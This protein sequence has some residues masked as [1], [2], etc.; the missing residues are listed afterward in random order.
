M[1][2]GNESPGNESPGKWISILYRGGE[3]YIA[4]QLE[5]LQIKRGQHRFLIELF[6]KDGVCQGDLV[7]A[8]SIDKSTAAHALAKLEKNGY[9]KRKKDNDDKR[10]VRVYLTEKARKIEEDIFSVLSVWTNAIA[11]GF[12][13]GEERQ[14]I[15][16]LKH[17]ARNA[18]RILEKLRERPI[19]TH[20][21]EQEK[22]TETIKSTSKDKN[23]GY[24]Q[25]TAE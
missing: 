17:M 8:L 25:D 10:F 12:S 18:D 16:Q 11:I 13:D 24:K 14:L 2:K 9:V 4:N 22:K 19:P 1:P 20:E 5:Q 7:K 23:D 6:H 3:T 21:L 15:T